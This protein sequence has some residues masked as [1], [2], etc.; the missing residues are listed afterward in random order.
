MGILAKKVANH[1][2]KKMALPKEVDKVGNGKLTP[3]MMKKVKTGGVMWTGAADAFNAMYDAALAAGHKLRNI[4]DYRPFEGQLSM[5]KDRYADK[6]TG[7]SPEV[8]RKYEGKTWYLKKGKSPSGTPGTSNHGFGLAIDLA[9]DNKGKI[10][11]IGGT[12]AYAWLCE[13]APKYGFYLQ[14]TPKRPDGSN[15]PEYEAWHW[16]YCIGDA[17]APALSG[18]APVAA[19]APAPAPVPVEQQKA[20][21]PSNEKVLSLGS[22]GAEVVELQKLLAKKKLYTAKAD[23]DFGKVTEAALNKFKASKGLPQ[24]GRAG[25]KVFALLKMK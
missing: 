1:P 15:N 12:A 5:F 21:D 13:N 24:D 19:P 14:G 25:A 18:A 10:Q 23:G 22:K 17:K 9:V 6:P 3:N 4:G 8:T 11:G 2:V 16:Q 20:S 7:R